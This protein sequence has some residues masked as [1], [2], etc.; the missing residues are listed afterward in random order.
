MD[1]KLCI[2][3]GANS[4]I[5]KQAAIQMA[6][7]D[8]HVVIGCRNKARGEK[9]L[10][11]IKAASKSQDVELMLIDLSLKSSTKNFAN[12]ICEKYDTVDVLIHNAAIFDI[13]QKDAKI[14]DEGYETVW[15][16][17]HINPVYLTNLLLEK[18]KNSANGRIITVSSKGLLAMP[19]LK[20]DLN[21]PEFKR[22]RFNMTKAYYQSKRAQVMYTYYLAEKLK[23]TNITVNCVRVTA[24]K[25][26]IS[27]HPE[28]SN[29]TKWV[30]AQKSKQSID[31]EQMAKTYAYLAI[32]D[33]VMNVSGKYFDEKNKYVKSNK[34]TYDK[35]NIKAVMEL[36]S[37]YLN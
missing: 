15:M 1:K 34:Y 8:Y 13:A 16:T 31:P 24:V 22:K 36:T 17:N 23:D 26:D 11:E 5:G 6:Q 20:I 25:I 29:F 10:I 14:S 33:E 37:R 7:A 21:D 3:T 12:E 35:N 27:R 32:N 30:Y 19:N 28:L 2:I 18:L 9:A 4:G